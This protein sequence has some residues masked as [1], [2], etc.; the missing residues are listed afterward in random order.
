[1][2]VSPCIFMNYPRAVIVLDAE[3]K[4]ALTAIRSLGGKGVYVVAGARKNTAPGLFSRYVRRRFTYP[5]PVDDRA[6]FINS[7]KKIAK[8]VGGKERPLL[9]TFTDATTLAIARMSDDISDSVLTI[10]PP[11]ASVERSFN[12]AETVNLA[13]GLTIKTPRTW[14][15]RGVDEIDLIEDFKNPDSYP[16]VVKPRH[17]VVWNESGEGV[18]ASVRVVLGFDEL[19]EVWVALYKKTQEP[20]IVQEFLRGEERGFLALCKDGKIL[21]SCAHRRIRSL[22]PLGGASVVKETVPEDDFSLRSLSEKMIADLSWTGP[23]MVEYKIDKRDNRAA[24]IEINGRFWGA[25]PLAVF[26]GV[27]FPY[28]HYLLAVGEVE[29]LKQTGY[30]VGVVSR[31]LWGDIVSLGVTLCKKTPLRAIAYPSRRKALRDFFMTRAR[32]DIFSKNDI[33]PAL[34]EP[35]DLF[36]RKIL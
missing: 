31:H 34:V 28:L 19:R 10:L 30:R 33:K 32:G 6:G 21:V 26:A 5:S 14:F 18:T 1:M 24:L 15:V 4:S 20:P 16:L 13:Q 27:D 23:I 35:V 2:S 9:Y 36:L 11:P 7:I 8:D 3:Y 29:E 17:N 22:S 12:K 25:L